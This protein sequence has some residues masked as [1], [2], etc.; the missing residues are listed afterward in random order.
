VCCVGVPAAT[1]SSHQGRL[2]A[3]QDD[4][5]IYVI[6]SDGTGL[7]ALT[8]GPGRQ[9]DQYPV[10][11]PDGQ[12]LAFVRQ[13]KVGTDRGE[14]VTRPAIFVIRADGSGL[15]RLSPR[16]AYDESPAWS[17]DG[18]SIA[19]ARSADVV[20]GLVTDIWVMLADGTRARR[21]TGHPMEDKRPTWSPDGKQ[22]AFV[23]GAEVFTMKRDGTTQ[24]PLLKPR[25]QGTWPSWSP[26]GRRIALISYKT[27]SLYVVRPDGR[28]Q[29]IA[30]GA[31]TLGGAPAWSPDGEV[32]AF[33]LERDSDDLIVVRPDG[34]DLHVL[35]SGND[36][37]WSPDSQKVVFTNS[38]QS[39]DCFCIYV[40]GA[41]GSGVR[42]I[43]EGAAP[44]W[45]PGSR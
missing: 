44:A 9:R 13:I 11:S 29:R 35:V 19:F 26:L 3:F 8:S 36:P 42:R 12:R 27:K 34:A 30:G 20:S 45:Q 16:G 4:G 21:V 18:R 10:W 17:P 22:I 15:R 43:A 40:I 5:D 23:R 31:D 1:A 33:E 14:D 6:A 41:D 28:G 25:I 7:R 32:I 37:S 38:S 24:R 2:I 39:D